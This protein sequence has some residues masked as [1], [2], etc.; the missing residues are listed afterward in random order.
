VETAVLEPDHVY[1]TV[2]DRSLHVADGAVTA[3]P[4][5]AHGDRWSP[6]DS[7]FRSVSGV[8]G[9]TVAVV[10]SG[11]G[12]DGS[13]GARAVKETG[14]LVLIQ[15]PA[16]ASHSA[17]PQSALA[18]GIA[19]AG[20]P[21]AE[22][23]RFLSR[24]AMDRHRPASVPA[25]AAAGELETII[26]ALRLRTGHDVS[27]YKPAT[28][29]R[30]VKRR[31]QITHCHDLAEYA[32]HVRDDPHEAEHLFR[33]LLISVTTFFRDSNAFARLGATAVPTLFD[34]LGEDESVRVWV[35]GC[36]TGE[37][38]YG[39]AMLLLEGCQRHHAP[40]SIQVLATDLDDHALTLA[41][42]GSYPKT[43]AADVDPDRLQR[44][45][46]EHEQSY[47]VKQELRDL[48][49]FG[50]HDLLRD[51]PFLRLDLIC[52][53]NLLIY[54]ERRAQRQ[55]ASLF[56]YALKPGGNL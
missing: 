45:F 48:V 12:H 46:I 7:L 22:L 14:G 55:L 13:L 27:T 28:L 4:F 42:E 35:A 9:D 54:L 34:R 23:A 51:P 39:V 21:L 10:L 5:D 2:P 40:P 32:A 37:E 1:I 29:Q 16:E 26:R 18:A 56:H 3:R 49:L 8:G 15:D 25:N 30:R 36:A 41:R 33:D 6:I 43:I 50:R 20:A 53:R 52:C 47:T 31:L 17:M 44:F 38:A 19:D 11:A 24:I